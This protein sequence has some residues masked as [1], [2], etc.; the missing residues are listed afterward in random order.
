METPL[1]AT[2][3]RDATASDSPPMNPRPAG[4]SEAEWRTRIDLA[5]F[6][7]IVAIYGFDDFMYT[8]ITARIPGAEEH[9]LINPFGLMFEE[10][11]ASSLVKLDLD[12]NILS[13]SEF[14]INYAGYVIHSAIHSMR[15]DAKW[16]AHFHTRDGVGVSAHADGLL[17]LTQRSVY[18]GPLLAYHDYEGVAL[19]LEERTRLQFDLGDKSLMILRNHG[20]LA[21]GSTPGSTWTSIY[22]LEKACAEQVAALA[23]GREHVLLAPEA[24]Q[25]EA[26]RLLDRPPPLNGEKEIYRCHDTLVWEAVL[27]KVR[28][29]LPGHD[30]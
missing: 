5:A 10:I 1:S 29:A 9:I 25:A 20:T 24:A 30:T 26:R 28:R 22:Q 21:L 3:R 4:I 2:I 13:D 19:N 6:Y 23:G 14:D 15:Q 11:T 27:R 18:F 12:G 7:R 17:P 8:H 16:I